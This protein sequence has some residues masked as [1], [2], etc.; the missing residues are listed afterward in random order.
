MPVS[1]LDFWKLAIDSGLFRPQ[2]C[3]RLRVKFGEVARADSDVMHLARWLISRGLLTRYQAQLLLAGRAG[4]LFHGPYKIIDQL[5][6]GMLG[7]GY[8][9]VHQPTSHPV[10]LQFPSSPNAGEVAAWPEIARRV[11]ASVRLRHPCLGR[12]FQWY[13]N[14]PFRFAVTEQPSGRSLNDRVQASGAVSPPEACRLIW[15]ASLALEQMHQAGLVH[16]ALRPHA[17]WR[18][19]A[20]GVL[21]VCNAVRPP[22]PWKL[23]PS[24]SRD[25]MAELADYFA[26]ELAHADKTPDILTDIYALGCTFHY[27]LAGRPPFPG[28]DVAQKMNRHATEPIAPLQ[29]LPGVSAEIERIVSFMMAKSA[30]VRFPRAAIVAQQ[31][32]EVMDQRELTLQPEEPLPTLAAFEASLGA[33]DAHPPAHAP[34]TSQTSPPPFSVD[35]SRKI[36]VGA[37]ERRA[38]SSDATL[39]PDTEIV[40]SV[41]SNVQPTVAP[42]SLPH[43]RS[44]R[45]QTN[46]RL[47][48]ALVTA[49][50]LLIAV[51]GY[52]TLSGTGGDKHHF[53][54]DS[55]VTPDGR[56]KLEENTVASKDSGKPD[57]GRQRESSSDSAGVSSDGAEQSVSYSLV[58]DDGQFL[59]ATPTDGQPISLRYVPMGAQLVLVTRPADML[60]RLEGQKVIQGLGPRFESLRQAWVR[61]AGLKLDEIEQLT[62]ALVPRN[63]QPPRCAL[64]IRLCQPTDPTALWGDRPSIKEGDAT[65][66]TVDGWHV[67]V[68]ASEENRVVAMGTIEDMTQVARNGG[69]SPTLRRQLA[70]LRQ[71]SDAERHVTVLLARNFLFADGRKLFTDGFDKILSPLDWFLGE[72]IQACLFSLH[73]GDTFYIEARFVNSLDV[74]PMQLAT[75]LKGRLQQVPA[76]VE[77]YLGG[78]QLSHWQPLAVKFPAMI[79]HLASQTRA[80]SEMGQAVLNSV[81]PDSA[82]HNLTLASELAITSPGATGAVARRQLPSGPQSVGDLLQYRMSLDIP[83][84]SLE[85]ALR[86]LAAE[87]RDA[88]PGLSFPFE[89]KVLGADLREEGIT[90]NQQI[91]DFQ[92]TGQTV[93]EIL[94][95]LVMKA[96]PVTTIQALSDPDQKL[97]WVIAADPDDPNHD[98][99]LITTRR[100]AQQ[101]GYELPHVFRVD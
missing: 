97:I 46:R 45:K 90:R 88:F 1:V 31:L 5:A 87:V 73:I 40:F 100:A 21:L 95:G 28:E 94:T 56:G 12:V 67:C 55:T 38:D 82:A 78:V 62:V 24:G 85:F 16:G 75:E 76:R 14:G 32:A 25:D 69:Q 65:I 99:V 11:D 43:R 10:I 57:I 66:Y 92:R 39:E 6:S 52:I 53:A 71:V 81:L 27:L 17:L 60:S 98:A 22:R 3:E 51:A 18:N 86:D 91:K 4:P 2:R 89:L 61:A 20:G 37:G 96:N 44:S 49:A 42:A 80:G 26:P 68:P 9:A 70:R 23:A 93:A 33:P 101:K 7:R 84:Q 64:V 48:V 13:E 54:A 34:P 41:A 74:T 50:G 79:R 19:T 30:D 59:W 63:E 77:Q 8:Q 83:Q 58:A 72:Q 47:T 36:G 29:R 35:G 15:Q